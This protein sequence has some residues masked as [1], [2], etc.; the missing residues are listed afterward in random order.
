MRDME[1]VCAKQCPK[2]PQCVLFH[3][4][5]LSRKKDLMYLGK[6]DDLPVELIIVGEGSLMDSL[7]MQR[8]KMGLKNKI[9][10]P[11]KVKDVAAWYKSSDIFVSTSECESFG[12]VILEAMAWSLPVVAT[13]TDSATDLVKNNVN[14]LI[15]PREDENALA[16]AL[17]RLIND[18]ERRTE[19]GREGRK[20]AAAY[21]AKLITRE[22]RDRIL[23][24]YNKEH[25]K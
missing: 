14:G 16:Y 12:M 17:Q 6:I 19:M 22:Y 23:D 15:V 24:A 20:I 10:F 11:G 4:A 7:V 8:D 1:H 13:D 25:S 18:K 5:V 3:P 9:H 2:K 21:D